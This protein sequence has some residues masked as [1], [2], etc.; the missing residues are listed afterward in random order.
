MQNCDPQ[1]ARAVLLHPKTLGHAALTLD[2]VLEGDAAQIALPV[3]GPGV[4]DATEI[5]FALAVSVEADQRAAMRAAVFEGVDLAVI[6]PDH[7][8][9]GLA[10][11]GGA[12]V[13]R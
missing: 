7:H 8:D 11:L 5:L 9:R 1:L 13:A 6:V 2:A 10:D 12:E 4:I 3:V